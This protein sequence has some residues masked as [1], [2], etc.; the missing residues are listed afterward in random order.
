MR[1]ASSTESTRRRIA[2]GATAPRTRIGTATSTS[3]PTS[4]PSAAPTLMSSKASTDVDRNGWATSGTSATR[5]APTSTQR[6]RSSTCGRRSAIE[7]PSQYPIDSATSTVAIVL[8]HTM[9][10][11]PKNGASS[12]AA[13]ISAPRVDTPDREDDEVQAAVR[14]PRLR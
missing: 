2:H 4:E 14:S 13:A 7:P 5:Q 9:V 1:P 10:D 11:A 8:A 3:T 12:R 6:H